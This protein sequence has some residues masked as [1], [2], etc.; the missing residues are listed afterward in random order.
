MSRCWLS[1]S[2]AALPIRTRWGRG[3]AGILKRDH[4]E[5]GDDDGDKD[6]LCRLRKLRKARRF[7]FGVV[8]GSAPIVGAV[9]IRRCRG[10]LYARLVVIGSGRGGK[11][12]A[13]IVARR[14]T[15]I[16]GFDAAGARLFPRAVG[17]CCGVVVSGVVFLG[18]R[19]QGVYRNVE[20]RH[21]ARGLVQI[22]RRPGIKGKLA[23]GKIIQIHDRRL[24]LG[25]GSRV[26]RLLRGSVVNRVV[27]RG[28]LCR[29]S[30]KRRRL[31]WIASRT[32]CRGGF[33]RRLHDGT[34]GKVVRGHRCR[35]G[36]GGRCVLC[37]C[38]ANPAAHEL[39]GGPG[40]SLITSSRLSAKRPSSPSSNACFACLAPEA[41]PPRP[42]RDALLDP[43]LSHPFE[44]LTFIDYMEL[45]LRPTLGFAHS[46][47]RA[48]KGRDAGALTICRRPLPW[49]R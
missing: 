4:A 9:G 26:C 38:W 49:P 8:I 45:A 18:S 19:K 15:V 16:L 46:R 12:V 41:V 5:Q 20:C 40:R 1:S 28:A 17:V 10:C 3:T 29:C 25:F 37:T 13:R 36:R 27:C 22:C 32:G 24:E 2:F 44:M 42:L 30:E 11:R 14:L 43:I 34:G 6:N 48:Q 39:L 21:A 35:R 33:T 31:G 23:V 47:T 7:F